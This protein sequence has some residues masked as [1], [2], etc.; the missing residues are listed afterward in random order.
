M[1]SSIVVVLVVA[2]FAAGLVGG[3]F[4][5]YHVLSAL[6]RVEGAISE[7]ARRARPF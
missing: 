1:S 4:V 3:V 2:G 5:A 7:V 6:N